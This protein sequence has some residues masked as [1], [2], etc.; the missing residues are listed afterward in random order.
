MFAVFFFL[1]EKSGESE[2]TPIFN[3]FIHTA[4]FGIIS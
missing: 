1:R 2:S 4:H 3:P